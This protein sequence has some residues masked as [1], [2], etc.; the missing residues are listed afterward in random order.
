MASSEREM[1]QMTGK[2]ARTVISLL[3]PDL[4]LSTKKSMSGQAQSLVGSRLTD[5]SVL[6]STFE[7]KIERMLHL[8][9]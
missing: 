9:H 2:V 8:R 3:V 7:A 5:T 6:M 1:A 4:Q